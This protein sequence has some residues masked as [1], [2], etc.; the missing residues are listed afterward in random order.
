VKKILMLAMVLGLL[1]STICYA[2][3]VKIC[4]V[5]LGKSFKEANIP[6]CKYHYTYSVKS[7]DYKDS[8]CYKTT[9]FEGRS[10]FTDL[11]NVISL[12]VSIHVRLS[13]P[14]D[15]TS[16]VEEIQMNFSKDTYG[17]LLALLESKF[18]K[19]SNTT[20]TPTQTLGG[21]Q[22]EKIEKVW[23]FDG[24]EEIYLTNIHGKVTDG[25]LRARSAPK[26]KQDLEK[27]QK[28]INKDKEK[29]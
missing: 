29:F 8:N 11:Q 26:V 23:K 3:P 14:C 2:E 12:P 17:S 28:R 1:V 13:N 22:F 25:F 16:E 4:G 18:G 21:A 7:Y 5:T 15:R 24:G 10:C 6:E 19:A 9:D 20:A 27:Q